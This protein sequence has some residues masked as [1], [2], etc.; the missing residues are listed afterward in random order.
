MS[1][2][3][4]ERPTAD[5]CITNVSP[6][7]PGKP[8]IFRCP[9]GTIQYF[10]TVPQSCA[11]GGC[12][13][14][15]SLG[16][17]AEDAQTHDKNLGL[18]RL[19]AMNNFIVVNA[20]QGQLGILPGSQLNFFDIRRGGSSEMQLFDF[21]QR[22]AKAFAVDRNRIHMGGFSQG[23][24]VTF[25]ILCDPTKVGLFASFSLHASAQPG[26]ADTQMEGDMCFGPGLA[27]PNVPIL[28]MSGRTDG[29]VPPEEV[30]STVQSIITSLNLGEGEMIDQGE[31]GFVQ[32]RFTGPDGAVL[33]RIQYDNENND[34][35]PLEGAEGLRLL[36]HCYVG[37]VT[38]TFLSCAGPNGFSMGQKVME[39][40]M[41]NPKR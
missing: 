29:I 10:V 22:A 11:D 39:F 27:N 25:D 12:G 35:L 21:A 2:A 16:G 5:D 19:G 32:R 9:M 4:Q 3:G 37:S 24:Q 26:F 7:P 8:R 15:I 17:L 30:E 33:E 6:T 13:L 20:Q 41:N 1:M 14:I 34:P 36:G 23:A 31:N 40:Y 18:R 28:I 38:Q